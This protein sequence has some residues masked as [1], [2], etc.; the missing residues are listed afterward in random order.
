L[1]PGQPNRDLTLAALVAPIAVGARLGSTSVAGIRVDERN[2]GVVTVIDES[3]RRWDAEVA[4]RTTDDATLNPLATSKHFS[5]YLRNGGTG[6]KPTD[7]G[8]G[9]AVLAIAQ[10]VNRNEDAAPAL[11]LASRAEVWTSTGYRHNA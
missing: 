11:A 9:R 3:G 1:T 5:L 7:E 10:A 8:V 6:H 4:R 2:L